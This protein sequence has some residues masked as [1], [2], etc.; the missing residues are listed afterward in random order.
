M[1]FN[2]PSLLM[3]FSSM[4]SFFLAYYVRKIKHNSKS[5]A[6]SILLLA[7]AFWSLMYGLELASTTPELIRIFLSLSYLGIA[8]TPVLCLIFIIKYTGYETWIVKG[9]D[10]VL[11]IIPI[12]TIIM[13]LTNSRHL[14]FYTHYSFETISNFVVNVPSYGPLWYVH[15]IYSYTAVLMGVIL[16]IRHIIIRSD[17]RKE[18][19]LILLGTIFPYLANLLYIIGIKPYGFLDITPIGFIG[20]GIFLGTSVFTTNLFKTSKTIEDIKVSFKEIFVVALI[21]LLTLISIWGFYEW[22]NVVDTAS[23]DAMSMAEP[24]AIG[25]NGLAV[26][27]LNALP[28]DQDSIEYKN[29]KDRLAKL[30]NLD[31]NIAFTYIYLKRNEKLYFMVDSE[32]TGSKDYSP[33]GQEYFD[34]SEEYFKPFEN[35]EML[36]TKPS[37]DRWGKWVTVLMPIKDDTEKEVFA[38]LAI[39]Y[40]ASYWQKEIIVTFKNKM[41]PSLFL[42]LLSFITYIILKN[43]ISLQ[44]S[45]LRYKRIAD[46]SSDLIW[47]AT[48]NFK[49]L[50]VSPSV[51]RVVG[52]SVDEYLLKNIEKRFPPKSV[53]IL[54]EAVKNA[55]RNRINNTI[56]EVEQYKKDK[57][58]FWASITI[59]L[60]KDEDGNLF[61]LHGVTRDVTERR[62]N[63]E[64]I[65]KNLE[66]QRILAEISIQLGK[67]SKFNRVINSVLEKLAIQLN[68]DRAYIFENNNDN[69]TFKNT[70]EWCKDGIEPQIRK[71][72]NVTQD[73]IKDILNSFER[74]GS[75]SSSDTS[76]LSEHLKSHLIPQGI[77]SVLMI[78]LITNGKI[79]GFIGFGQVKNKREWN[80]R[81]IKIVEIVSG[82]ISNMMQKEKYLKEIS[83]E[84]NKIETIVQSIGDGLFVIDKDQKLTIFNR[85]AE[86]I[87]GY[88]NKEAIGKKYNE[89][90]KFIYEKNEKENNSFIINAFNSAK[91]QEMINHTM[92]IKKNGEKIPVAD[93]CAPLLGTGKKVNGCVVVF[94]D[95]TKQKEID[96]MKSEFVSVASHQLKTPLSGIKWM[97]ELLLD[98]TIEKTEQEKLDYLHDINNSNERMLRLVEDLL[99]VSHIETGRKFE[100]VKQ[101]TDLIEIVAQIL[102]DNKQ[103]AKDKNVKVIRCENAPDRFIINCD[104]DK[105]R[106]VFGNLI[107]NAIKYSKY[108]GTVE[109]GCRHTKKDVTIYVKDDG[110]GIPQ[111]QQ[112]RIFEKFFRANNAF[113]KET[114][115]TGLGLYIAKA[116]VEAHGGKLWFESEEN[117]GSTF[118][119]SLPI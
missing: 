38:V 69:V 70:Y 56:V 4:I 115:G 109:I 99:D 41:I 66:E 8:T 68:A 55:N 9:R 78:S 65:L 106:Q 116:I 53:K 29:L 30:K 12:F 26:R 76:L 44:E 88:S 59:S 84:K 83:L 50:Y 73:E 119:F 18:S 62:T 58:L 107:N 25:I 23:K 54:K 47:T 48:P 51:E 105:I 17:E 75:F 101:N 52:Y 7:S 42:I 102:K 63:Q 100:I 74:E 1:N 79:V 108:N 113:S 114:D 91:I 72:Q 20:T 98:E 6:F 27:K 31:P 19:S 90:L 80:Q 46:N 86:I 103:L 60:I 28:A 61:E 37:Q 36:V 93:S 15:A 39:D 94:R 67:Y 10:L 85:Q 92:L 34:A 71:L 3:I 16:I 118:Y 82:A 45:E 11:F 111:S 96:T 40:P 33:P 2:E 57:T 87:S 110:V 97:C 117:K 32:P 14:L 81:D 13:V 89:V 5:L 104:G 77:K 43:R 95:V 35:N 22:N 64:T 24:T 49:L 21:M 112:K